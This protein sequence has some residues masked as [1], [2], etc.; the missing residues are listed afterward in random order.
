MNTQVTNQPTS[1]AR[2]EPAKRYRR[3]AYRTSATENDYTI[4]VNLPGVSKSGL[5]INVEDDVLTVTGE[6]ATG[7]PKGWKVV[8]RELPQGDYLLKLRIDDQI[9]QEKIAAKLKDGVLNVTLPKAE[10]AKPRRI[11]VDPIVS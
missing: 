8:H 2:C 10:A 6:T 4:E 1:E 9:D 5:S 7:T 11:S 3:P